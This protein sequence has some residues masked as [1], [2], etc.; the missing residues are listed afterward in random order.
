MKRKNTKAADKITIKEIV[1]Q[2]SEQKSIRF[3]KPIQRIGKMLANFPGFMCINFLSQCYCHCYKWLC[4]GGIQGMNQDY[5]FSH[6]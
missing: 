1:F 2:I 3:P 5:F 6:I 4:D